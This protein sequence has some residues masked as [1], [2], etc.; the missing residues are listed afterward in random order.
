MIKPLIV[1]FGL[2]GAGKTFVSGILE[3]KFGY[4]SYNGDD[5]LPPI[6]R[7]AL[8]SK[9]TITDG[10][11]RDF[12]ESMIENVKTITAQHD[13]VVVHQTFLK[14]YM[15]KQILQNFPDA[16]FLL[17]QTKDSIREYR[18]EQRAYFNLGIDYLRH[19]SSLFDQPAVPHFV[20]DNTKTGP[21]A[22]E[23]QLKQ[24]LENINR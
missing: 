11:R 4:F 6:M 21:N 22:V 8:F 15:R 3:K 14:E 7:E 17:V 24:I 23:E 2:P 5:A 16:I 13:T 20:I 9:E 19:M 12:V 18:Y 1:V 10:M